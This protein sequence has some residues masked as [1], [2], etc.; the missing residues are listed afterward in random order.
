MG[1]SPAIERNSV[2]IE[3]RGR[4]T[5]VT[6]ELDEAVRKRFERIARQVSQLA[7]LEVLLSEEQNPR[8][9][10]KFVAEATLRVKGKTIRA[11]EASPEM[12]H[13]I[14][15]LAEDVRRQVKRD[16]EMRRGRERS[17]R[18]ISRLRRREA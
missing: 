9:T 5:D 7:E 2:R 1:L 3:I 11:R 10:D 4:N 17:R 6:A 18:F 15:E 13:S 8:I 12:L 14:H 16:R